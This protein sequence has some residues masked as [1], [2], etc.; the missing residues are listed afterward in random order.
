MIQWE[1]ALKWEEESFS[2]FPSLPCFPLITTTL[3]LIILCCL[4]SVCVFRV[5]RSSDLR[6]WDRG[7]KPLYGSTCYVFPPFWVSCVMVMGPSALSCLVLS[8]LLFS[9]LSCLVLSSLAIGLFSYWRMRLKDRDRDKDNDRRRGSSTACL[10]AALRHPLFLSSS[11]FVYPTPSSLAR[12]A[13]LS[14][15]L[16]CS[17][18]A[19]TLC[20]IALG[21]R[22]RCP[23]F[24]P[25]LRCPRFMPRFAP[26]VESSLFV[27]ALVACLRVV[28]PGSLVLSLRAAGRPLCHASGLCATLRALYLALGHCALL[29]VFV[30]CFEPLCLSSGILRTR[31][32][33]LDSTCAFWTRLAPLILACVF[34]FTLILDFI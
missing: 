2:L 7:G 31:L 11:F 15:D 20:Y 27:S 28:S 1:K 34:A 8:C 4:H 22:L 3:I 25:R 26:P 32:A 5:P 19:P 17:R 10:L 12:I 33:P 30:L 16:R 21:S 14:L 6:V 9:R 13:L 24:T 29:W 18:L 23:R